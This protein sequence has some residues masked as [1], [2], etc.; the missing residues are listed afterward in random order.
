M[1]TPIEIKS[2]PGTKDIFATIGA[3]D[4][5]SLKLSLLYHKDTGMYHYHYVGIR[6]QG[7]KMREFSDNLP[8]T[9]KPVYTYR[10]TVQNQIP[11]TEV[12]QYLEKNIFEIYN[13]HHWVG[14]YGKYDAQDDESVSHFIDKAVTFYSQ[15]FRLARNSP[16][17]GVE[18]LG[19]EMEY[20]AIENR[21]SVRLHINR[22]RDPKLAKKCKERDGYR[23]QICGFKFTDLYGEM[24]H[25]FA[26]AHHIVPL[27][28]LDEEI[29]STLKDIITVCA[30]CHRMLH[31][32][33]GASSD[34]DELRKIVNNAGGPM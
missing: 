4:G 23:C 12:I 20:S 22:E 15:I 19:L 10:G 11:I 24:G 5:I 6:A 33:D 34:I 27:H 1:Q 7:P 29:E 18:P 26:E 31:R 13:S 8:E 30:N 3:C 16:P 17:K 14:V 28:L 2:D 25:E 9:V 21:Q 32:M